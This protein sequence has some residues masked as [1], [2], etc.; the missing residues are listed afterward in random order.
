MELVAQWRDCGRFAKDQDKND[1]IHQKGCGRWNDAAAAAAA[2]AVIDVVR[3][4]TRTEGY[5]LN[6]IVKQK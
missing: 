2:A 4:Y 1:E 6:G 3:V 5:K